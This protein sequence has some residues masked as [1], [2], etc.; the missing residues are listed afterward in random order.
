MLSLATQ[1]HIYTKHTHT[2]TLLFWLLIKQILPCYSV[3][4]NKGW[5]QKGQAVYL[6]Y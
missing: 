5:D 4:V 1:T 6:H 2:H 3:N